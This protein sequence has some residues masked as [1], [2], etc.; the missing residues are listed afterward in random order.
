M[1]DRCSLLKTLCQRWKTTR[2]GCC[3]YDWSRLLWTLTAK[4]IFS[5][6]HFV[7]F[8]TQTSSPDA[9]RCFGNAP[10][11][12]GWFTH[13]HTHVEICKTFFC[14]F[15]TFSLPFSSSDKVAV[16]PQRRDVGFPATGVIISM[17]CEAT[18][19]VTVEERSRVWNTWSHKL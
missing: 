10:G 18:W 2:R 16:R 7:L 19:E 4:Q 17:C 5:F 13:T 6:F 1:Y 8:G 15:L 9:W 11:K 12:H 3:G 14:H